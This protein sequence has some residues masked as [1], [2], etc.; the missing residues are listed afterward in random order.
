MKHKNYETDPDF[1]WIALVAAA[2]LALIIRY[3]I[4]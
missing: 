1:I 3:F 4:S 2:I